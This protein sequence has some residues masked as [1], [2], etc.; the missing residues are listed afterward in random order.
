MLLTETPKTT[1]SNL[2]NNEHQSNY[3]QFQIIGDLVNSLNQVKEPQQREREL[4]SKL[5]K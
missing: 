1:V 4:T 5:M 3:A 2:T